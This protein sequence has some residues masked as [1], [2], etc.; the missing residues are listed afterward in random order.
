MDEGEYITPVQ[1]EV[2]EFKYD[3]M[4]LYLT[5]A[6]GKIKKPTV[7]SEASESYEELSSTQHRLVGSFVSVPYIIGNVNPEDKRFLKY[8]PDGFLDEAQKA[9][10]RSY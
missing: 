5:V 9:A 4:G 10:K 1:L 8:A 7:I 6:L 2:K 3:P